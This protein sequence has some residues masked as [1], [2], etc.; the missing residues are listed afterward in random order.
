MPTF[1][2]YATIN[3]RRKELGQQPVHLPMPLV[4]GL[5]GRGA[6]KEWQHPR[7][8]VG[9]WI[10]KLGRVKIFGRGG[11]KPE[12]A[13]WVKRL[14]RDG[15]VLVQTDR[16]GLR[17]VTPDLLE[18]SQAKA[19]LPAGV[20][21]PP[22]PIRIDEPRRPWSPSHPAFSGD[23]AD[24]ARGRSWSDIRDA[25]NGRDV[26]VFD[27]ETTGLDVDST[28]KPTEIAA[29]RIRN[30]KVV[31]RFHT[32]VNPKRPIPPFITEKT[33]ITDDMVKGAPD[34]LE[35]VR[36]LREFMGTDLIAA[37]NAGFDTT[38]LNAI[39]AELGLDR[40]D[41]GVIDTITLARHLMARKDKGGPV[42]S[43][44]LG[45]LADFF[46]IDLGDKAHR[47]DADT[48]ATGQLLGKLLD[49]AVEN[50]SRP[51]DVDRYT[52]RWEQ[53]LKDYPEKLKSFRQAYQSWLT[54][55]TPPN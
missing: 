42:D 51:Y 28:D 55:W 23:A 10:E 5:R 36:Q 48:E 45:S 53:E 50:D 22:T 39:L 43:H 16:D 11:S 24:I 33:G 34:Y 35:A 3:A 32:M 13:G 8:R 46:G 31:D 49:Y 40:Q 37:H 44:A 14:N 15:S 25:I 38:A 6:W 4:A 30:G 17:T 18:G 52:S 12:G 27:F 19:F 29:V 1:D 41:S 21:A 26:V 54:T 20:L 9:R 2:E 47:A 7:D